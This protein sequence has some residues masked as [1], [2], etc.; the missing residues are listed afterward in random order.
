M[1]GK[2]NEIDIRSILQ[3]VEL[4]QRTG[5]LFVETYALGPSAAQPAAHASWFVFF[6]NGKIVYAAS[7]QDSTLQRLRDYLYRYRLVAAL[8]KLSIPTIATTHAPEYGYLWALL[9]Q[10]VLTPAQGRTILRSMIRETL[11]DLLGLHDGKFTFEISPSLAPQL[12]TLEVDPLV[13]E[14]VKQVQLWKQLHPLVRSPDALPLV[15]D[16]RPLRRV[17]KPKTVDFLIRWADGKTSIRQIARYLNQNIAM[18]AKA[19][20]PYLQQGVVQLVLPS[21]NNSTVSGELEVHAPYVLCIDDGLLLRQTVESILSHHGYQVASIGDPIE[22]LSHAIR[23]RPDLILCDIAM[24]ELDGYEICAMLRQASLF[25]QTPIIMLTGR[26]GFI[27]RVRARMVGATD[28]LTKPFGPQELVTLVERY[29]N[30]RSALAG[31][32]APPMAIAAATAFNK[33]ADIDAAD[34]DA[35]NPSRRP[36][37]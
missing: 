17:L 20:Y 9:E 3:L 16:D 7:G 35:A 22:A 33:D 36:V 1:Q 24:P 26:D 23:T 34:I 10:H 14:I 29:G 18:L 25:R 30:Q 2:L 32:L 6:D 37:N 12:L 15:V 28:Y 4:G 8:D 19:V 21:G 11:F 27:D 13:K 5:E 31:V